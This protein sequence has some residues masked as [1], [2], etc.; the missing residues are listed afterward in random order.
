M[1]RQTFSDVCKR[2][3]HPCLR[4]PELTCE[5]RRRLDVTAVPARNGTTRLCPGCTMLALCLGWISLGW[6]D[7]CGV[8]TESDRVNLTPRPMKHKIKPTSGLC[9]T[10]LFLMPCRGEQMLLRQQCTYRR[11]KMIELLAGNLFGFTLDL[12]IYT[13][14]THTCNLP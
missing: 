11:L 8:R 6:D 9:Q 2:I 3:S 4:E 12:D 5:G 14:P 7:N 10:F 13:L 1:S